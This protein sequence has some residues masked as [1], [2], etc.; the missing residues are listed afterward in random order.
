MKKIFFGTFSIGFLSLCYEIIASKIFFSYFS[1]NSQ[2]VAIIISVFLLGL[3][4]GA[5]LYGKYNKK[6]NSFKDFFY[7][8]NIFSAFYFY[9]LL[10]ISN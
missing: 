2:S 8:L 10:S 9:I 4:I 3:S 1:E 7:Y 6:I 5:F